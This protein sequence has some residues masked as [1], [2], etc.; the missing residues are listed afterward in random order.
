MIRK[1]HIDGDHNL[2]APKSPGFS[3]VEG[4]H[5]PKS[6]NRISSRLLWSYAVAGIPGEGEWSEE[7]LEGYEEAARTMTGGV[8]LEGDDVCELR[9]WH[10]RR[11]ARG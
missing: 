6:P 11:Q 5:D 10:P 3:C 2:N 9:M 7:G 8:R 4:L 1:G